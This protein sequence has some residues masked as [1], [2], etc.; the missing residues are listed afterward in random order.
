MDFARTIAIAVGLLAL[1]VASASTG[2]AQE[3]T[4]G[5]ETLGTVHFTVSCTAEAQA[6]FDRAVA[7][8]HSFWWG[9][10]T[11]AFKSALRQDP[12]CGMAQWGIAMAALGNPF[13]WPPPA[14]ALA[15]GAAALAQGKALS[16]R[17]QRERDYLDALAAFYRDRA[18]LE[19][20]TRALAYERAMGDLAQRCPDDRE[21]T[22]FYA[23]ALNATALPTDKSYANSLKAAGLLEKIFAEQPGHPGVAHYLIHSYDYPSIAARGLPAAR[24]Y[25]KIAPSVPHALHM[26]SH[27]F[28]RLGLWSESIES[29]RASAAA[30]TNDF[31]RMHAMDYLVY[32][33]LQTGQDVAARRVADGF[34]AIGK[35][36][37]VHVATAYA[38]AAAPARLALE[39]QQWAA[40]AALTVRPTDFAWDRFPHCEAITY[41]A[42]AVGAARGGDAVAARRNID[43]LQALGEALVQAKNTY[44]AEQVEIQ[45]LAATGWLARAEQRDQ[46]AVS[47]LRAAADRED[48]TEKHPATPAPVQPAR[49]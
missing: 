18:T 13:G 33:Y 40:A 43:R 46:E 21:A 5:S 35:P 2:T 32:A 27:I 29:N 30:A 41:F 20:R 14:Q 34:A 19:H 9:P 47:L 22:V 4:T 6:E 8:L 17:T 31:D 25:L 42:R 38:M 12:A 23:L 16:A 10:A 24:K 1:P 45:R 49:E 39:R 15:E 37:V 26:P 36:N 28:T 44:W 3:K 7:L 48:A 11:E